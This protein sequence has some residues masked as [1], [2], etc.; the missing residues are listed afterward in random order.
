MENKNKNK[1]IGVFDSGVG[2]L[3]V[4]KELKLL[5]PNE[6]YIYFGDTKNLP[7]GEKTKQELIAIA[8]D[9]FDF[10]K[11][12]EVKAVVMACNTSSATVYEELKD[13]YDFEIYPIVQI[14]S[15][16]VAQKG[17]KKVAIMATNATINSHA[18]ANEITKYN[19]NITVIEQACPQLVPLVEN[20]IA[21]SDTSLIIQKY[22]NPVLSGNPDKIILGCTHYPHLINELGKYTDKSMF[23]NPAEDFAQFII[24][25]L[26]AKNLLTE[27]SQQI[28]EFYVS[29]NPE[30][31]KQN[32]SNFIG[33]KIDLPLQKEFLP[34]EK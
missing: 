2:G 28:T 25:D 14:V 30:Q 33:S 1:S 9:I 11:E 20:K 31:F 23:L 17:Y 7:S 15:Q 32:A 21:D 8:K 3:T 18:Y 22:L 16:F 27:N 19:Q 6:K 13:N 26:K 29:S 4:L 24:E 12:L 5:C 10:Y 34:L